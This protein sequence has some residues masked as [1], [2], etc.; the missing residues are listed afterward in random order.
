MNTIN[1]VCCF[2]A[3]LLLAAST[4]ADPS[5][6]LDGSAG[7]LILAQLTDQGQNQ[8]NQIDRTNETENQSKN[9][10]L[11]GLW[12]WGGVPSGFTLNQSTGKLEALP[13][14]ETDWLSGLVDL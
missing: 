11:E 14:G 9:Q 10:T 1:V 12:S 7:K 2:A 13:T 8:S 5:M 4:Q 3:I 6:K